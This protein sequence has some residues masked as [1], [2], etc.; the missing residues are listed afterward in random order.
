[1]H[2]RTADAEHPAFIVDRHLGIPVLVALLGGGD[3]MLAPIL[4]PLHRLAA[5]AGGERHADLF[6]VGD[7]LGAEAAADIRRRHA[8]LVLVQPE[9]L[10]DHPHRR[11]RHLGGCPQ[12]RTVFQRVVARDAAATLDRMAAAA[13]LPERLAEHMLR[14]GEHA[15]G[16]AVRH[17]EFGQQVVRRFT[18]H[19]RRIGR[20]RSP[21]VGYRRQRV[22]IDVD[23]RRRILGDVAGVGDDDR[24]RF[25]DMD[26]LVG[27][28][29]LAVVV[30]LVVRAGQADHQPVGGEM[31]PEV[32]VG[33]DRVHAGQRERRRGIDAP[34][35]C[36]G[37]RAAHERRLQQAGHVNVV[38]EAAAAG[39]QCMVLQP[40]DAGTDQAVARARRIDDRRHGG[41]GGGTHLAPP[42]GAVPRIVFAAAN[43]AS[44]I[45]W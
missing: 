10:A 1:M 39:E 36:M 6:G 32:F 4:D 41:R 20:E 7:Q 29:H 28:Q 22:E 31:R 21:A 35:R 25:A 15:L 9:D 17:V 23:Q 24:D 27:R 3:E 8:D 26:G 44:T 5:Q 12:R 19:Q 34:D 38:D 42:A 11:M 16:L 14:L 13:V 40:R 37:M 43:V 18:V 45:A 2:D 33:I 30:L